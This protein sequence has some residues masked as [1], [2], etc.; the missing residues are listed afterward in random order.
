MRGWLITLEVS[1][2]R[3][4]HHRLLS[5]VAILSLVA[6]VI[7][8]WVMPEHFDEWWGYGAFFLIAAA[9][10]ALYAVAIL[11]AP[12]PTL[13]WVG[14]V[15]NLAIIALWAITRTIGIPGFG[16]HAGEI[17]EIGQ[18]DIVSKLVELLLIIV[19]GVLLRTFQSP[20]RPRAAV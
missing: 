10:Q 2:D 14:I 15:G 8:V 6:A 11:R 7:H 3:T 12:T 20:Q 18:I 13:L 4:M 19:L 9:A 1:M 16:P 17:E 5:V